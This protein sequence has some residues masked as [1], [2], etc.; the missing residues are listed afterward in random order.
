LATSVSVKCV[1]SAG[2]L[3]LPHVCNRLKPKSMHALLC[4]G[5]RSC[6][7]LIKMSESDAL[8]VKALEELK[9][10]KDIELGEG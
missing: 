8:K 10:N 7:G 5:S 1:F 3:L 6:A 9:G 2:P 4:L